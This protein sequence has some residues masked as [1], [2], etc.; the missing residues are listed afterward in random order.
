MENTRIGKKNAIKELVSQERDTPNRAW[1]FRGFLSLCNHGVSREATASS[2][3]KSPLFHSFLFIF[4]QKA[5]VFLSQIL[6]QINIILQMHF[7][8]SFLIQVS[9]LEALNPQIHMRQLHCG[10]STVPCE[11]P[12]QTFTGDCGSC[13]GDAVNGISQTK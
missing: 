5:F 6:T 13:G 7:N 4:P 1:V 3:T 8:Q 10:S 9:R 12:A 2:A 11:S